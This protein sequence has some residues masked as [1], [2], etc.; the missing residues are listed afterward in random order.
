MVLLHDVG[1]NQFTTT[2]DNDD[3]TSISHCVDGGEVRGLNVVDSEGNDMQDDASQDQLMQ[4]KQK[5]QQQKQS[6]ETPH[7]ELD[8]LLHSCPYDSE[9]QQADV[10]FVLSPPDPPLSLP[11]RERPTPEQLEQLEARRAK[12]AELLATAPL[13]VRPWLKNF[14][15]V[16]KQVGKHDRH[17]VI[18]EASSSTALLRQ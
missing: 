18:E 10:R 3:A 13:G 14:W 17:R 7:E 1:A 5:M 8:Y 11:C 9:Q 6:F 15:K 12:K 2:A 4:E 16:S